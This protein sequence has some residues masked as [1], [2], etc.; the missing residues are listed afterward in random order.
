MTMEFLFIIVVNVT[1]DVLWRLS[2]LRRSVLR[3]GHVERME[4]E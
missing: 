1:K 3:L 4:S 2:V